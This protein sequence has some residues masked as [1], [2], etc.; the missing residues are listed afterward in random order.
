MTATIHCFPKSY[1]KTSGEIT[2]GR[3]ESTFWERHDFELGRGGSGEKDVG[4][5]DLLPKNAWG[6]T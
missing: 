5:N 6:Q 4:R 2:F 3:G 1:E